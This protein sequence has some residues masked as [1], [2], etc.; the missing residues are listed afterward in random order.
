MHA[1]LACPAHAAAAPAR[2][3][4]LTASP[5]RGAR[6]PLTTRVGASAGDDGGDDDREKVGNAPPPSPPAPDEP[7][8]PA[9]LRQ[10]LERRQRMV[11]EFKKRQGAGGGAPNAPKNFLDAARATPM[12][13]AALTRLF[14]SPGLVGTASI[15]A[16][17]ALGAP[18][19]WEVNPASVGL[20]LEAAALLTALDAAVLL[21]D[22]KVK[23]RE[24]DAPVDGG[25]GGPT[26]AALARSLAAMSKMSPLLGGGGLAE[27]RGGGGREGA[28]TSPSLPPPASPPLPPPAPSSSS[29]SSSPS[30]PP[31]LEPEERAALLK[32]LAVGRVALSFA[33]VQKT[34]QTDAVVREQRLVSARND[35]LEGTLAD[36]G[37]TLRIRHI[38]QS[39]LGLVDASHISYPEPLLPKTASATGPETASVR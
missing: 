13:V 36:L 37:S 9:Q 7:L 39:Q 23:V 5:V 25:P 18:F 24:E 26:D 19:K 4:R 17:W 30:P 2:I 14:I 21:P 15:A 22:W 16:A 34:L 3:R 1:H 32:A 20:A 12:L 28:P 11:A 38:A 33:V 29:S 27:E 6:S 8:D 35:Q 31:L 10:L